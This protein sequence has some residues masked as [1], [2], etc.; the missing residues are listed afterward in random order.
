MPDRLFFLA[1]S[2]VHRT[3]HKLVFAAVLGICLLWGTAGA[4]RAPAHAAAATSAAHEWPRQWDGAALRPLALGEVEARFA[5]QFPGQIARMTDGARVFVMRH[6]TEP[7]RMLHPATDCYRA[8]GWRIEQARL[9]RDA[10][11]RLWRC[12]TARRE[13]AVRVCERIEDAAGQSFTDTSA[14]YWAGVGGK[15]AGPWQAVTLAT[16]LP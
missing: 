10:Q 8:L 5:R 15:S 14:W 13:H 1:N 7:T 11:E 9:E 2:F 4:L 16:P 3:L 12:F 6:V